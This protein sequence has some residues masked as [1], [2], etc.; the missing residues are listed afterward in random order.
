MGRDR[1]RSRSRDQDGDRDRND[2]SK[3]I[4]L[5]MCSVGDKCDGDCRKRH[6]YY[7]TKQMPKRDHRTGKSITDRKTGKPLMTDVRA[8]CPALYTKE[9]P[10]PGTKKKKKFDKRKRFNSRD[11]D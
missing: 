10:V 9:V 4:T 8:A 1:D 2:G 7:D 5:E 6:R 3:M 11:D